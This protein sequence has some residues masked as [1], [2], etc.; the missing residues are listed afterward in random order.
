MRFSFIS[1]IALKKCRIKETIINGCWRLSNPIYFGITFLFHLAVTA[2][3]Q[4]GKFRRFGPFK[5][6]LNVV[7]ADNMLCFVAITWLHMSGCGSRLLCS[8]Y[9]VY[10]WPL[11][12]HFQLQ[13]VV[14]GRPQLICTY[15]LH[16]LWAHWGRNKMADH[17][18]HIFKSI[19]LNANVC[20]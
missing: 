9:F 7:V 1:T 18:D 5:H 14:Y 8:C 2:E 17:P 12:P 19:F 6:P 15:I 11:C 13:P 10:N 3:V 20:D 16:I 4:W